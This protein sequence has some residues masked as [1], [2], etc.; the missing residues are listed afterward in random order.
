MSPFYYH[1]ILVQCTMYTHH[2]TEYP[3][4]VQIFKLANDISTPRKQFYV[5]LTLEE[6]E[7]YVKVT[8][9]FCL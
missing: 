2:Y 9:L 1:T 8:Q 4:M 3:K 6:Q 7:A 5:R